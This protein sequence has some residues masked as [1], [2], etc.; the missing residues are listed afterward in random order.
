[1]VGLGFEGKVVLVTGGSRGIGAAVVELLEQLGAKVAY[2]S[3]GEPGPHGLQFKADVCDEEQMKKTVEMI[4]HELGPIYGV[5]ANA[6]IT[7]DCLFGKMGAESWR[8]VIDTNLTGVFNTIHPVMP[9]MGE[10]KEGALVFI[11]SIIGERGGIGQANYAASKAGL[12]GLAKA[13]GRETARNNIRVNVVA[14][15]F[16][17]T[18]ML[19]PVPEKVR[20]KI[21][22]EI[23]FRRFGDPKEIAW[24]TAFLLS[25]IA[26]SYV[27]GEV[28][29]VNG[30]QHK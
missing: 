25:P 9:G 24:A 23:P 5:V 2:T 28:L 6:G 11:S 8:Q 14:P 17:E 30:G 7:N 26:S 22:T 18:D 1:M 4:E 19:K 13:L 20:E 10:R 27:T 21:L 29:R 15:G 12:I 3:R 16:I